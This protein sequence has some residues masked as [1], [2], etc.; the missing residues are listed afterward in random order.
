MGD[1]A[2]EKLW[3]IAL[4]LSQQGLD[5]CLCL[6]IVKQFSITL[7][8]VSQARLGNCDLTSPNS[9]VRDAATVAWEPQ[10]GTKFLIFGLK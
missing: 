5:A 3:A 10:I 8:A 1:R 7:N 9:L 6:A 4:S 2:I